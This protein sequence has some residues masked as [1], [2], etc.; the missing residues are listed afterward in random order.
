MAAREQVI[1][2]AT[3]DASGFNREAEKMRQTA[4]RAGAAVA[5]SGTAVKGASKSVA[6]FGQRLKNAEPV[7]GKAASSV[8]GMAGAMSGLT[9]N[10]AAGAGAA[11]AL[12]GS[13]AGGG[14]LAIGIA[15]ITLLVGGLAEAWSRSKDEAKKA[16]EEQEAYG[17]SVGQLLDAEITRL[18]DETFELTTGQ[19]AWKR[20]L[21]E[22]A[23]EL[24]QLKDEIMK[25]N[26]EIGEQ[27]ALREKGMVTDAAAGKEIRRLEASLAFTEQRFQELS[28]AELEVMLREDE[29][30]E[31]LQNNTAAKK[32]AEEQTKTLADAEG[33]A[34]K[35]KKKAAKAVE[36][37]T[38][39]LF[40][41]TAEHNRA[42]RQYE[43]T[44][45]NLKS[46]G[47]GGFYSEPVVAEE[48]KGLDES[49]KNKTESA[50]KAAA[51]LDK[52]REEQ[53]KKEKENQKKLEDEQNKAN[54][55]KLS[56]MRTYSGELAG[57][58]DGSFQMGLDALEKMIAGERVMLHEMLL[59]FAVQTAKQSG[60]RIFGSGVAT[61]V[62]G[63]LMNSVVPGSGT[64]AVKEGLAAMA[65]GGA[66]GAGGAVGG[67][68]LA[69][70][71]V[72]GGSGG[73]GGGLPPGADRGVNAGTG[74]GSRGAE[75]D[76]ATQSV[77][78]FNSP[79][80]ADPT[81]TAKNTAR[82]Q[83]V[84]RSDLLVRG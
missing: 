46:A 78:V 12:A 52:L 6:T 7:I 35:G 73:G 80:Y 49:A 68:A 79:V 71:G 63:M 21:G 13:F 48:K 64:A 36:D 32:R 31:A 38:A 50:E 37:E 15:G 47:I 59:L 76:G 20:E 26:L 66:L 11:A 10:T 33:T 53:A 57:I 75:G 61:F 43:R 25:V 18:K 41:N 54:E 74:A 4:T 34:T 5:G 19:K 77:Y 9:T 44:I 3:L 40:L 60:I 42:Q 8:S 56:A 24:G 23:V 83:R 58:I 67:G 30:T 65:L 55:R 28:N 22:S 2:D 82:L 39:A 70:M 1:F 84:A 51:R 81:E 62:D 27:I 72:G 45:E 14:L 16:R 69:K 29:Y 17:K